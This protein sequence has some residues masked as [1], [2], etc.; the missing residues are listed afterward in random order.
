[1]V[2]PTNEDARALEIIAARM[3]SALEQA[4]AASYH[5]GAMTAQYYVGA[6]AHGMPEH[7]AVDLTQDMLAHFLHTGMPVE[8]DDDDDDGDTTHERD[9]WTRPTT[10]A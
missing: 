1:M 2:I 4:G 8:S 7:M 10:R 9:R 3:A 6:I 5:L